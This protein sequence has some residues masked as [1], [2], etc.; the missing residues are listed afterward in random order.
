M[1]QDYIRLRERIVTGLRE[2]PG[3]K[4]TMPN[5]AFYAYPNVSAYIGKGGIKS[6]ADLA[7]RL[8]R[9][10]HVVAVPGEA[11]GTKE[12]IRCS[13]ATSQKEIDR[14]LERMKKFFG[15]IA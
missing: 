2:I 14:G 4:C 15:S 12:H 7:S 11:F 1:R 13:Y 10:A 5:G 6:A 9:E 3:I 8:L